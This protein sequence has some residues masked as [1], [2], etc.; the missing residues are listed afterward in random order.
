MQYHVLLISIYY[1]FQEVVQRPRI[2]HE[3]VTVEKPY[4]VNAVVCPGH[5]QGFLLQTDDMCVALSGP[6]VNFFSKSMLK[7]VPG[8]FSSYL[9]YQAVG[10]PS[11]P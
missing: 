6:G 10:P 1:L 5:V 7:F 2:G 9:V 3:G 11:P 4:E 8:N